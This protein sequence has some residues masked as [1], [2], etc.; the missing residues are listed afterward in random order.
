MVYLAGQRSKQMF[1][2]SISKA[3][4][5]QGE[6]SPFISPLERPHLTVARR[7]SST[8]KH[9]RLFP[10]HYFHQITKG[11]L[12][13]LIYG[14]CLLL[15]TLSGAWSSQLKMQLSCQSPAN[16]ME[17]L[18]V[19]FLSCLSQRYTRDTRRAASPGWDLPS[20]RTQRAKDKGKLYTRSS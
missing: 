11:N 4:L 1:G 9:P 13:S 6:L 17:K 16:L 8:H 3:T 14:C 15:R 5:Q 12:S 2:E 7:E 20:Q 10:T 18:L 19:C